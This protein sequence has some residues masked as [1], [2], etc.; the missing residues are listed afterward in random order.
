MWCPICKNEYREGITF[1]PDC[2]TALTESLGEETEATELLV[3]MEKEEDA[4]KLAAYL[5]YSGITAYYEADEETGAFSVH[6]PKKKLKQAKKAFSAFY[7]VEVTAEYEQKLAKALKGELNAPR[8]EEGESAENE[9]GRTPKAGNGKAAENEDRE[10]EKDRNTEALEGGDSSRTAD[11]SSGQPDEWE[12]EDEEDIAEEI[13]EAVSQASKGS[14]VSRAEKSADYRSS[15]VTFTVF[16]VLG[17]VVMVLHWA[18][19]FQYFSTVS[20]V[21]L[22]VLFVVFLVI[23]IDSFRRAARAKEESVQEEQFIR[24]LTEWLEANLTLESLAVADRADASDEVNFFNRM[25]EFQAVI[26]KQFGELD[27]GFLEQFTEE[28]YNNHFEKEH[29]EA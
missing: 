19:V 6:V 17:I 5:D 14:Y 25:A 18:G 12:E 23:G 2:K 10:A 27:P 28:Y 15:G 11:A 22:S 21:I 16:G 9:T 8:D 1:C 3:S 20:A 4:K 29:P 26:K 24:D 13:R 7:T